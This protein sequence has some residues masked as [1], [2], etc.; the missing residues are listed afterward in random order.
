MRV[1]ALFLFSKQQRQPMDGSACRLVGDD[2]QGL[3]ARPPRL[4]ERGG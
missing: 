4:I 2:A 1:S 3:Q